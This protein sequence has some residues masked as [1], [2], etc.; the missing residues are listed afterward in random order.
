[1]KQT[2]RK[3]EKNY[4]W[5]KWTNKQTSTKT[6][7]KLRLNKTNKRTIYKKTKKYMIEWNKQTNKHKT[8]KLC[9]NEMKKQTTSTKTEK[10][11]IEWNE[12]TSKLT[13]IKTEKA[14]IANEA[15]KVNKWILIELLLLQNFRFRVTDLV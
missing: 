12:Q 8:E 4:D 15:Q 5:M 2:I 3:K 1:M 11:M 9:L 13:T 10:N 7:K 14:M 6:E